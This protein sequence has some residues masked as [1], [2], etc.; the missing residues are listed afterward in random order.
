MGRLIVVIVIVAGVAYAWHKGWIS[1]W[2]NTA[3]D[4]SVD[5]VKRTQR[6][7]TKVRPIDAPPEEK[8]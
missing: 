8:K 3:V 7:A 6:E 1:Q 4:S 5:S 2:F